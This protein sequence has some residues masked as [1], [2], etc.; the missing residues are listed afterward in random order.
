[1]IAKPH[2]LPAVD[3]RLFDHCERVIQDGLAKFVEVGEALR[4]IQEKKFYR[5]THATFEAYCKDRWDF[6][7][8]RA[9]QLLEA[10]LVAKQVSTIVDIVPTNEAQARELAILETPDERAAA[11]KQAV[12]TAPK[13]RSGN[14]DVTAKHIKKTIESLSPTRSTASRDLKIQENVAADAARIAANREAEQVEEADLEI[15]PAP[16][17]ARVAPKKPDESTRITEKLERIEAAIVAEIDGEPDVVVEIIANRLE[18]LLRD[19][20]AS[21]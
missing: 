20:R 1:M 9:Y 13:D 11:W 18:V 3:K 2:K 17:F 7:K 10:S 8:S 4:E 19:M 5:A 14:P 16:S 15:P 12:E 21:A 6:S